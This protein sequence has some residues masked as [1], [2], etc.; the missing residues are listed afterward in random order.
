MGEINLTP[1]QLL[2][3]SIHQFTEKGERQSPPRASVSAPGA[4]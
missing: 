3:Y 1:T 2:L 4:C